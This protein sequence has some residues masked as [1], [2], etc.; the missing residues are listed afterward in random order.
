[1][2]QTLKTMNKIF[3]TYTNSSQPGSFSGLS[4]FIKNTNFNKNE[5]QKILSSHET[6]TLHHPKRKNFPRN[7][8]TVSGIDITWHADL[9]D[10][11]KIKYE[12]RQYGYI[13]TCIDVFS[14]YAWAIPIK[15][16]TAE[17]TRQGFEEIFKDGRKPKVI[18]IDGGNEF[19][20]SCKKFLEKQGVDLINTKSKHKASIVERFNRTLKEKMWRVF[21]LNN[22]KKYLNII[23]D[24]M[25]SYNNTYHRSIKKVPTKVTTKNESKIFENLYG[26]KKED[27]PDTI[28]HLKF[29][30]GDYVRIALEKDIFE[31]GYTP[32]WSKE[33]YII[34]QVIL[35]VPPLYTIKTIEDEKLESK[36]YTEELQQVTYGEFPYDTYQIIEETAK[37]ILVKKLNDEENTQNWISKKD[38][39]G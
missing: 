4:G 19:K 23:S 16:K 29:K 5:S 6:Y 12:N 17:S 27:G 15:N 36:F 30:T 34:D 14:K 25:R 33:V 18:Y 7:R 24:L 38:F 1:M 2:L 32:N 31:K 28:V 21:T 8:I 20:G 11:R 26:Y 37:N 9:V 22:N 13:L 35:K 39:Y 3:K 10:V